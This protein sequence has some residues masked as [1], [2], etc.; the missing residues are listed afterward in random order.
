MGRKQ[1]QQP[2]LFVGNHLCLDFVNT[3]MIVKGELTDLLVSFEDLAAWLVQ[4]KLLIGSHADAVSAKLGRAEAQALLEQAKVLR[5]TLR[6]LAE[7]I[8]A[9]KPIP[10][11]VIET[12]N[13]FLAQRPGYPQLLRTNGGFEQRFHP[14]AAQPDNLLTPIA[15]AASELLCR[16]DLALIKKCKN[17]ACILYFYDTTKNH[18]R[19]WCSMQLCGNRMKVAAFF[20]R[21]T[22]RSRR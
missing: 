4:S 9:R 1:S 11:S 8:A 22:K 20:Q 15:E 12:I 19:N 14:I 10:E 17:A 16:L 7:R 21:R 2:F 6:G 3:Q 18:R 13:Q 5:A